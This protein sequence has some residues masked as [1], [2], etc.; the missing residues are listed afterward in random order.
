M[1][2]SRWINRKIARNAEQLQ[3]TFVKSQRMS[4]KMNAYEIKLKSI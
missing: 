3:L 2:E 1:E 4:K